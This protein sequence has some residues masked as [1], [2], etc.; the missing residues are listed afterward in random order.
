[1][2][3]V[4]LFQ[5]SNWE[6]MS[7]KQRVDALQGLENTMAAEQG[8][9]PRN[10]QPTEFGNNNTLGQYRPQDPN[11]L[12]INKN[13]IKSNDGNYQAMQTTIHEGRHAYQDDCITG[14]IKPLPQDMNKVESWSHNMP[15][16]GGHYNVSGVEYR[17]QP[18]EADANDYAREKLDSY[19][20]QFSN[21][22]AYAQ[23]TDRRNSYENF[24]ENQ[25]KATY[26]DD[27][28]QKINAGIERN[29][30]AMQQNEQII[31]DQDNEQEK[32]FNFRQD[33]A[34]REQIA[35][36]S[37]PTLRNDVSTDKSESSSQST[38]KGQGR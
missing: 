3:N 31:P 37:K 28:Q 2:L 1:M 18:V 4:S 17:Y 7:P 6:K 9:T 36:Q 26:G 14:K 5:S 12:Y 22:P 15:S 29:Y 21:D 24:L 8:R 33:K 16:R 34:R 13:L 20:S 27:Y 35:Q 10:I 11:N 30:Q 38:S 19:D 23:H 25:A 32:P